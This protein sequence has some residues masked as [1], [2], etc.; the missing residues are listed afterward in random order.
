M[1]PTTKSKTK[2]HL[3]LKAF[4]AVRLDE[5]A[6][7]SH[8]EIARRFESASGVSVTRG[9]VSIVLNEFGLG[10]YRVPSVIR[11]G[12]EFVATER[13]C[14]EVGY[15]AYHL[16]RLYRKGVLK[17]AAINVHHSRYWRLDILWRYAAGEYEAVG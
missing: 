5:C 8:T 17:D 16:N 6:R 2:G 11:D 10:R 13:A 3:T 7:L 9:A 15:T 12:V 1:A 4:I 14:K